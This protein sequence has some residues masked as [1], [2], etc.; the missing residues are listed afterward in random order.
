MTWSL[1][2]RSVLVTGATSGIGTVVAR[3]LAAA[4]AH[5]TIT[6]RNPEKGSATAS[7]ITAATGVD[8]DVLDVD[9]SNLASVRDAALRFAETHD[10][11]AVLVN[12]AGI[13]V[14]KRTQSPDGFE[15]TFATNHLGPFL[16]TNMLTDL[17]TGSAPS[18]IINTSS[19]AHTYAKE[20]ILFDDIGFDRRRYKFME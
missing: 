9:F 3:E 10:D 8:V 12:N 16:L 18:R 5:V 13:V 20:G 7:A 4:G 1:N 17:L 6:A 11:L 19:V 14:G 15:L 2:D